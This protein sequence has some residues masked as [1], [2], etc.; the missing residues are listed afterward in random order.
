MRDLRM[1][2]ASSEP[3]FP[4]LQNGNENTRYVISRLWLLSQVTTV[5]VA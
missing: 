2:R 5:S 1:A 3:P 4:H